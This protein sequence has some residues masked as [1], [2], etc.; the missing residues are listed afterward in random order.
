MTLIIRKHYI[1]NK[2]TGK[3]CRVHYSLDNRTDGRKCITIYAKTYDED[4]KGIIE[5]KNNSDLMSDYFEKDRAVLFEDH[6]LYSEARKM[7]EKIIWDNK[8]KY[9]NRLLPKYGEAK[10]REYAG[11]N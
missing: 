6:P 10:A 7:V 5:Y 1:Q 2:E 8:V 11:I 3:K 9:F 4:M